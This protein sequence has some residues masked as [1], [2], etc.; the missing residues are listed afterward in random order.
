MKAPL[1][2]ALLVANLAFWAWT[3]G[4]L[5]VLVGA[6]PHGDRDP[7]RLARQV[8]PERVRIV[9][10]A[11]SAPTDSSAAATLETE[12]APSAAAANDGNCFEAGPF[13]P[14]ELVAAEA[15]LVRAALPPGSWS[16]LRIDRPGAWILYMGR[17]ANREQLAQREEELR[18]QRQN[19]EPVRSP[20]LEPGLSLGRFD[21]RAAA[22][23]ALAQLVQRGVQG[24]RVLTVA[25]PATTHLLRVERADAALQAQL[26]KLRAPAL[27]AGFVRCGLAAVALPR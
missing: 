9:R 8:Q 17:F 20:D 24:V 12:P 26:A 15:A 27:G 7:Q 11:A 19:F 22:E 4:W 14:T 23:S 13:T 18:R 21:D 2:V 16:D 3:Q 25:A 6:S 1:V 10:T 5:D